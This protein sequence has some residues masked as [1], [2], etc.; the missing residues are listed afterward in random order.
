MRPRRA[1]RRALRN[2]VDLRPSAPAAP[3]TLRAC[4]LGRAEAVSSQG[5]ARS[6]TPAT[7]RDVWRRERRPFWGPPRWLLR[8][9]IPG[10][11]WDQSWLRWRPARRHYVAAPLQGQGRYPRSAGFVQPDPLTGTSGTDRRY[12]RDR[13]GQSANPRRLPTRVP[14]P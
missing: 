1:P 3:I 7:S 8:R 13:S 5:V 4:A 14:G 11:G 6:A 12:H 10:C 2:P 9:R